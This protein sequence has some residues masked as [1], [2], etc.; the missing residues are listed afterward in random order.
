[1]DSSTRKNNKNSFEISNLD[2]KVD[3]FLEV[4][5]QFVDGVSGTR[6]GSRRRGRFNRLSRANVKDVGRWV[7]EKVDSIFEDEEFEDW[8][9]DNENS[10]QFKSFSRGIDSESKN[11]NFMNKRPLE[12]ISLREINES[13]LNK[14]ERLLNPVEDWPEESDFKVHKW[15]RSTNE[16]QEINFEKSENT[17]TPKTKSFPKSRRRRI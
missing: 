13:P 5:R 3:Q 16:R 10:N 4:G 7:S 11:E 14:S 17:R 15:Q 6:P 1:M 8:D 9:D 2:R 12:A